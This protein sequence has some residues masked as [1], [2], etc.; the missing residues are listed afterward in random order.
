MQPGHLALTK[1]PH[2][3]V[4]VARFLARFVLQRDLAQRRDDVTFGNQVMDVELGWLGVRGRH[5][6]ANGLLAAERSVADE[7]P[8]RVLG[9]V[10]EEPF[11]VA[12]LDGRVGL[13]QNRF[14][15]RCSHAGISCVRSCR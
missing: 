11:V 14:V 2:I 15:C 7:G 5:P 3:A 12:F 13:F 1:A 10:R 6:L 8:F 4:R 9:A